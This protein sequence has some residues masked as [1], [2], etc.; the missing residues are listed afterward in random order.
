[1]VSTDAEEVQARL[2]LRAAWSGLKEDNSGDTIVNGNGTEAGKASEVHRKARTEVD[3]ILKSGLMRRLARLEQKVKVLCDA[4]EVPGA[5]SNGDNGAAAEKQPPVT[6][7]P[8]ESQKKLTEAFATA[9]RR[10][11]RCTAAP[12]KDFGPTQEQVQKKD[13]PEKDE[14]LVHESMTLRSSLSSLEQSL[15][16]RQRQIRNLTDQLEFCSKELEEKTREAE[17]GATS[18]KLLKENPETL[19]EARK[20]RLRKQNTRVKQMRENLIKAREQAKHHQALAHQQRAFFLQSE[21]VA[22]SGGR[23]VTNR[24]P[25]GEVFLVLQPATME[26]DDA[27][28]VFDVGTAVANPYVCDSWP[29]EPNVLAR[30]GPQEGSMPPFKEETE[31]DLEEEN[32][33]FRNPFRAGLSLR[34]PV[35]GGDR[36]DEEDDDYDGPSATSR[37]L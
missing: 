13:P 10:A 11:T 15:G 35:H 18:W 29:F 28:E 5:E 7:K 19:P 22:A 23:E 21:R 32:R 17:E 4:R 25:C 20:T 1:M 3:A 36:S 14:G 27:Q 31:E 37:S 9:L 33:R 24:H 34:L 8:T 12:T 2:A 26:D 16:S 30:R 6:A